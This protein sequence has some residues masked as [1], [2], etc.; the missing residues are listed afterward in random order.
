[1]LVYAD[2]GHQNK[3]QR[4]N[5]RGVVRGSL[6]EVELATRYVRVLD[7][8]LR[9]L[10]HTCI[11]GGVGRYEDRWAQADALGASVYLQAHVNAGGG[12][13]GEIF[14]DYRSRGRGSI[15]AQQ[16]A[17]E[18]GARVPWPVVAK[19]CHPDDDGE[20]RDEDYGEAFGCIKG[21]RA[22]AVLTE[23][24]FIDGPQVGWFASD[25]G[26][27]A[28]GVGIAQGLAR[29]SASLRASER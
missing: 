13:R 18:V 9:R 6:V 4:I 17:E 2:I 7:R 8:E 16:I 23:S 26:L 20:P 5:D 10:G 25:A 19:N 15:L 22:V 21:V 24:Y 12:D 27:E 29:W 3:P 1:L 14:Y 11:V 28:V